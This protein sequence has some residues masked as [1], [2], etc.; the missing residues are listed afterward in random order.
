[1]PEELGEGREG[2]GKKGRPSCRPQGSERGTEKGEGGVGK[3]GRAE[4]LTQRPGTLTSGL[5]LA[6]PVHEIP[7]GLL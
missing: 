4:P 6:S 2:E 3:C 5:S 7:E 1:M